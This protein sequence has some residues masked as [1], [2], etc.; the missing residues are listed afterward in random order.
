MLEITSHRNGEILNHTHGRENADA[1]TIVVRGVADPQSRVTVN[2]L[3]TVR[4]DREFYAEV[5]LRDRINRVME[6]KGIK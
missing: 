5:P 4:H 2:G 1:L 3:P 6:W